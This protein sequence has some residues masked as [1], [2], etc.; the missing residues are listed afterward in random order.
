MF[1][2]MKN[3]LLVLCIGI[4]K[5]LIDNNKKSV[6]VIIPTYNPQEHL[7]YTIKSALKQTY[8]NIEILIVD[9]GSVIDTYALIH[10][11]LSSGKVKYIQRENAGT[12]AARN[13]GIINSTGEYVAFLDHDD[14]WL[15][16]KIAEQVDV[17]ERNPSCGLTYC[18][19]QVLEDE[20]GNLVDPDRKGE[21]GWMYDK[22]LSRSYITTA[23]Q[24]MVRRSC[25]NKIG[26]FDESLEIVDDY[27]I[28]LKI[29]RF[30]EIKHDDKVM[31]YW[32]SHKSN[33][34]KNYE[35][36]QV[37]RIKLKERV[38]RASELESYQIKILDDGLCK[39]YYELA[40]HYLNNSKKTNAREY[41]VKGMKYKRLNSIC[42]WLIT[43][44]PYTVYN[45][46]KIIKQQLAKMKWSN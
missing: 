35:R 13:T 4:Y 23:S 22:F 27:D 31:T 30:F 21:S 44:T 41:F 37:A 40:Y 34:S 28:Y 8:N 20:T 36:T 33:A 17:L 24:I 29:S 18:N 26:I 43:F 25:F 45:K 2:Q 3:D 14:I 6:S 46:L 15:P 42:Y 38:R 12:A 7:I 16:E 11:Y 32:R 5:M 39:D 1:Y 9:D 10:P 19:F